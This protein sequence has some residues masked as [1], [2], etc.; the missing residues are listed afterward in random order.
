MQNTASVSEPSAQLACGAC[1]LGCT[2]GEVLSAA[3]PNLL[4]VSAVVFG[5][6]LLALMCAALILQR[7]DSLGALGQLSVA[8]A[9]VLVV[10][11]LVRRFGQRLAQWLRRDYE[12]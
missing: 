12:N 6:P 1:A 4:G 5:A 3:P 2:T 8:V 10:C 9:A 7:I 11:L